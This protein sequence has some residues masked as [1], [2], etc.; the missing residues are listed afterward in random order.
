LPG[1][2]RLAN[3][4]AM[5]RAR[6]PFTCPVCGEE[7]PPNAKACPECGACERSGWSADA[8]YDGL[9][10]PDEGEEF[11]Y[12]KFLEDEFGQTPRRRGT[13]RVWW[14]VALIVLFAFIALSLHTFF[15][16]AK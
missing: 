16:L 9:D 2:Y 8:S 13:S 1:R 12:D 3:L 10:L 15:F 11:D 14:I 6:E 7:V 5:K 4:A